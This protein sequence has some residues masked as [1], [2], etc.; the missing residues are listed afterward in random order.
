[1]GRG[2]LIVGSYTQKINN[3][4]STESEIVGADDFM[5]PVCWTQYFMQAQR[6]EI[7]DNIM[8]Q[9]NKSSILL[10]KMVKPRAAGA[11]KFRYREY[12]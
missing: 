7:L 3:R 2:F 6:Y 5:P 11:L 4:S 1:M 10:E 9:D 12:D 8:Y